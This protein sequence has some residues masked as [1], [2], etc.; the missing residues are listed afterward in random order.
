NEWPDR[1]RRLALARFP[2]EPIMFPVVAQK[3]LG[4]VLSL[5][6]VSRFTRVLFLRIDKS[7]KRIDCIEF[8]TADP[9]VKDFPFPHSRRELPGAIFFHEGDRKWPIFCAKVE[10]Y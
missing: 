8:I 10:C 3:F 5:F 2:I 1:A 6:S 9:A 4:V 7:L